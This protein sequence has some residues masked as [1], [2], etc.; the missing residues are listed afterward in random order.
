MRYI[1]FILL[2]SN[3]I[4]TDSIAKCANYPWDSHVEAEVEVWSC[5]AAT[6][7]SSGSR[8]LDMAQMYQ[9]G[10]TLSGT[11]LGV[12]VK[13]SRVVRDR[14]PDDWGYHRPSQLEQPARR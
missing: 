5:T 7:A 4:A 9:P 10:A 11:L 12:Q 6:L 1:P 3:L 14:P 13:R 8:F 2:V